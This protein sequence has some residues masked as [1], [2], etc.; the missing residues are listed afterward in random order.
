M[1]PATR[2]AAPASPPDP[3]ATETIADLAEQLRQ[4]RLTAP[5]PAPTDNPLTLRQLA[6]LTGLPHSTLGNAE[7]GRVLPRVEVVYRIAQACGVPDDQ[8]PWWT[9]ARNRVAGRRG[10]A[11]HPAAP[12][13]AVERLAG[14]PAGPERVPADELLL[15]LGGTTV[16]KAA[17]LLA[18]RAPES[19][20]AFLERL[21]PALV[22]KLLTAMDPVLAVGHLNGLS[23]EQA[24]ACLNATDPAT[25]ARL[26][27]LTP[28]TAAVAHLGAMDPEAAA[29]AL[30]AMPNAALVPRLPHLEVD[31]VRR[32]ARGMP[33]QQRTALLTGASLPAAVTGELLFSL[34]FDGSLA[35]VR[36]AGPRVGARLLTALPADPAAGLLAEL[37][38]REAASMIKSMAPEQAAARLLG[39][40][41]RQAAERLAPLPP[42]P[43]G[44][45]L[46]QL[47]VPCAARVLAWFTAARR[48]AVLQRMRPDRAVPIRW[49]TET[50][51]YRLWLPTLGA[52]AADGGATS[53]PTLAELVTAGPPAPAL[54]I[55][56]ADSFATAES[57]RA[58]SSAAGS[59]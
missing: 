43:L 54:G 37:P 59:S 27:T 8:L 44:D 2:T 28:P 5:R 41:D 9:A 48:T 17:E 6:A 47:P 33:A 20:V 50:A 58:A 38:A 31:L 10:R 45:V 49:H 24:V 13:P 39:L 14:R 23:P 3:R 42:R 57:S 56:Y 32:A 46:A 40:T 11:P 18:G 7:S 29:R 51:T 26:L 12:R 34:G 4:L 22:A 52:P 16:D 35:L 25:A 19:V 21:H 36:S 53:A 30:A 55:A 1:E 15:E